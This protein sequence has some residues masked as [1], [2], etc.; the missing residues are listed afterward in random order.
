VRLSPKPA[1]V[2]QSL[3]AASPA[4]ATVI[5]LTSSTGRH[6]CPLRASSTVSSR[7]SANLAWFNKSLNVRQK[8]AVTRILNG[9]SRPMP[10]VIFG[11]PGLFSLI[12]DASEFI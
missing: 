2:L 4:T 9:Q 7:M 1:Q 8:A 6:R 5:K 3:Q 11:P 10:Y 12:A